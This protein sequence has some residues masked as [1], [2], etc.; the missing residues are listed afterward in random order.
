MSNNATAASVPPLPRTV[1]SIDAVPEPLRPFYGEADGKWALRIDGGA[2]SERPPHSG[3]LK[4]MRLVL[5]KAR[6]EAKAAKERAEA[7]ERQFSGIDPEEARAALEKAEQLE[8][9]AAKTKDDVEE[10]FKRHT[11]K[12][13]KQLEDE[14]KRAEEEIARRDSRLRE[15]L[16]DAELRSAAVKAGVVPTA[17]DDVLLRGRQV[18]RLE[19]GESV[20]ARGSDGSE[21]F[22]DEYK[23][24]P[25]TIEAWLGRLA[26][27]APHLFPQSSGSGIPGKAGS[28]GGSRLAAK[29][30]AEMT[31]AEKIEVIDRIKA[32]LGGA[33][34]EGEVIKRFL[35][36]P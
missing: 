25:L 21:I 32:Q 14:R 3:D 26:K 16:V 23:T 30:R 6:A 28:A 13:S 8:N 18:F 12:L 1:D 19:N 9:Q 20:V 34:S 5:D 27:D 29:K 2:E 4:A 22:V 15:L 36:L 7:I 17:L 35:E 33:V 31:N 11:A 10:K 24:Q